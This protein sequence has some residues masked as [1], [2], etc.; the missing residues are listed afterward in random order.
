MLVVNKSG[1][2]ARFTTRLLPVTRRSGPRRHID[3]PSRDVPSRS[4]AVQ[5][6]ESDPVRACQRPGRLPRAPNDHALL[7][8]QARAGDLAA[9]PEMSHWEAAGW[10]S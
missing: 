6:S 5:S 4:P 1:L 2:L 10:R 7:S 3:W 8:R 9:A